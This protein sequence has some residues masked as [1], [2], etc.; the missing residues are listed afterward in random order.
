MAETNATDFTTS[1]TLEPKN[2]GMTVD[3]EVTVRK[4]K[5]TPSARAAEER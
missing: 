3:V 5:V 4:S 2:G 1:T